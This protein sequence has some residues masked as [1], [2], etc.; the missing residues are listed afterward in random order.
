[1]SDSLEVLDARAQACTLC[2]LAH[3]RTHVVFG[4][5]DAGAA[6]M[7][8]G[9]A[10][11]ADEDASGHPF[12]GRSGDLLTELL[13]GIQ[14]ERSAVYIAN[15]VKCRPWVPTSRGRTR[16]RPPKPDE[17]TACRDYLDGQMAAV[18]PRVVISLGNTATRRLLQ[19]AE[20]ISTLR[21]HEYPLADGAVL[22]PTFH[23]S[24]VNRR[25]ELRRSA[26]SA[27]FARARRVLDR[28]AHP[29][30]RPRAH[31]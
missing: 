8:V 17:V 28:G 23:P 25:P 10:P 11:G 4:E 2:P 22:V 7:I 14:L 31:L 12:V 1:M 9:E 16:N 3:G 21:D 19:T 24:F 15:V 27:D 5:G 13:A 30:G 26:I 29:G 6:L 20:G 18:R